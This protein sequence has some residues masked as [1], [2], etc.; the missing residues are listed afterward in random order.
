MRNASILFVLG[1]FV[2]GCANF[3]AKIDSWQGSTTDDLI[4]AWGPPS[5]TQSLSDG[6][7]VLSY[8]HGH[9]IQGTTYDCRVWFFTD[10]S[11]RITKANGEGQVGGCNRFL[12]NK[13]TAGE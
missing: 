3:G 2:A 13:K 8:N 10:K 12:G 4:R 6:T 7:K 5:D 9:S 1:L 11:G